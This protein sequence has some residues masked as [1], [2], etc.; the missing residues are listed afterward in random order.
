MRLWSFVCLNQLKEESM[1]LSRKYV[2]DGER[3][4]IGS[5]TT[6][7]ADS[8]SVVR[9]KN[10]RFIGRTNERFQTTRDA[11]GKLVST[12]SADPGL[13]IGRRKK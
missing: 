12:N 7:F 8:S 3:K 1:A 4:I 10:N 11:H 9:D 2:R 5:V 13:L 6:G